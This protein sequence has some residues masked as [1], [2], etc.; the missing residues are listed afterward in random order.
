MV[1][2]VH[3]KRAEHGTEPRDIGHRALAGA[4]SDLAAMG[5]EA[6]EAYVVLGLPPGLGDETALEVA[7][8]M[9][10]LAS[11]CSVTIAGGDI[12]SSPALTIAV[13]VV[14]W[15]DRQDDLVTRA[16]AQ[17]G[18]VVAVTGAL[19][20][21][22]AGLAILDGRADGDERLVERYRR[23]FPRLKEGSTLARGGAHAMIDLSDGLATDGEHLALASAVGIE[24][25]L[26]RLPIADGVAAVAAQIGVPAGELAATA[27]EDYELCACLSAD[28]A[29]ALPMLTVIGRVTG[30]GPGLTFRG[31]GSRPLRGYEHPAA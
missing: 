28:D 14:G 25:D 18:D 6:G 15:A 5:A 17:I 20:A 30:G 1:D 22:G 11:Q 10:A 19:G 12:V 4:L 8:G 21:S 29:G 13:T 3:F 7:R 24:I 23:P 9:E 2:G 27:G 16:G 26:E 31:A